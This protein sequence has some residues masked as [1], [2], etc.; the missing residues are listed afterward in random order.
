LWASWVIDDGGI[1]M[2]FSG[3]T[4]YSEDFKL[5]G[6]KFSYFDATFIETGAYNSL[7]PDVHMLPEESVQAHIDL[8]G[9]WLVPIHN[10]TFDLALH[11]WEE[12]FERVSKIALKRG[13]S[14]CTPRMG[15]RINLVTP[16]HG[17]YWWRLSEKSDE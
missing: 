2:F 13:I 8:R 17:N 10:G 1:R 12:P 6:A 4:G 11:R 16:H 3:D 15:Q 7:W 14:L 5:I 9:R